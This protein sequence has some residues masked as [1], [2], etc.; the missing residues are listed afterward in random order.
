MTNSI[1]NCGTSNSDFCR[2]FLVNKYYHAVKDASDTSGFKI[3]GKVVLELD[4][5]PK[6][7]QM[8]TF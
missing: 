6:H 2:D 3:P 5:L 1:N 4:V 7:W 8:S